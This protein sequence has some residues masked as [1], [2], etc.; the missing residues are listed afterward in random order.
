MKKNFI[1]SIIFFILVLSLLSLCCSPTGTSNVTIHIDLGLNNKAALNTPE[2]S[3][4]D[5]IFRFFSKDAEAQSAP[6]N[7][8]SVTLNIS[9]SDMTTIT[10]SY[11]IPPFPDTI[12]LEVPAGSSRTFEVLATTPSA[13]LRGATTQ[14]LAGGSTVNIPISMGLY[15]T[16]IIIPDSGTGNNTYSRIIQID[17]FTTG[18]ST[19]QTRTRTDLGS[20]VPNFVPEDIDF[21]NRGRIYIANGGVS[22]GDGRIIRIDDITSTTCTVLTAGSGAGDFV[23]KA[24]AIDRTNNIMY[25]ANNGQNRVF[26]YNITTGDDTT[27]IDTPTPA[28]YIIGL[29]INGNALYITSTSTPTAAIYQYITKYNLTTNSIE[30]YR[31]GNPLDTSHYVSWLGTPTLGSD[32]FGIAVKSNIIYVT[33]PSGTDD[34]EI[35]EFDSNLT[36]L[37]HTGNR[38]VTADNVAGNFYGPK[39]ILAILNRKFYIMDE[40]TNSYSGFVQDRLV[41]FDDLSMNNWDT[42]GTTGF[43]PGVGVGRFF[44]YH[45]C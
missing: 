20:P 14:D 1:L 3:I 23:R 31:T 15:E 28:G 24:I 40:A 43:G 5:R 7:I 18:D 21:D 22:T 36:L 26:I 2:N 39:R 6:A 38:S 32:P 10:M 30:S 37:N 44:F 34:Y 33:N 9:A 27:Y 17:D 35:L 11:S 4:I 16:K 42:Y 45:L 41:S 19:W 8:T 13:T 25:Y 12:T 29:A